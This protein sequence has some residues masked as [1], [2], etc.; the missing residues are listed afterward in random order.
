MD[1]DGEKVAAINLRAESDRLHRFFCLL[2]LWRLILESCA[3]EDIAGIGFNNN[4]L[5][6]PSSKPPDFAGILLVSVKVESV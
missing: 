1:P 5:E 4:P 3:G 6:P 2:P